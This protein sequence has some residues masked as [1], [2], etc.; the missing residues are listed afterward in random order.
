MKTLDWGGVIKFFTAV[1]ALCLYSFQVGGYLSSLYQWKK[2]LACTIAALI[3][4]GLIIPALIF[5]YWIFTGRSSW[6]Q[7]L[8]C[9]LLPA[10]IVLGY[11]LTK[12]L[13]ELSSRKL[14]ATNQKEVEDQEER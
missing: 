11:Y 7:I 13:E 5:L 2:W 10:W 12:L 3:G 8:G 14:S 9:L 6:V 4:I 1:L